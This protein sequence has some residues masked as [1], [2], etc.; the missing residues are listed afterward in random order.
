MVP[1]NPNELRR[2]LPDLEDL[3]HDRTVTSAG[4]WNDDAR[5]DKI[6]DRCAFSLRVRIAGGNHEALLDL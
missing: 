2:E 5:D 6:D 3:H 1:L 4:V